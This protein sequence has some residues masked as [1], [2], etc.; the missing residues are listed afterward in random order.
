MNIDSVLY[1]GKYKG[2][3]VKEA[4]DSGPRGKGWLQWASQN[5][6]NFK[7]EE[8]VV[9]YMKTGKV[10]TKAEMFGYD[11]NDFWDNIIINGIIDEIPPF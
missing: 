4:I 2:Q 8:D 6:P 1:F 11:K 9:H 3:T 10:I 7:L 5:I